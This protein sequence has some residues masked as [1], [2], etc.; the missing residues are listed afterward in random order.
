MRTL[1]LAI[2]EFGFRRI[3]RMLQISEGVIHLDH[4]EICRILHILRK[5][6]SIIV[7]LFLQN[8]SKYKNKLKHANLGRCKFISITHFY[9]ELQEKK[10]CSGACFS[11]VTPLNCSGS[12]SFFLFAA[13]AFKINA[14]MIL[15]MTIW[16]YQLTKQNRPVCEL[17]TSLLFNWF[18]FQ[19]LPSDPK[20]YRTFREA[21]PRCAN[22]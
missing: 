9:R 18:W 13:F 19:N 17:G 14:S 4:S 15:K 10:V 6:N 1:Y 3:W 20:S 7:L 12:K 22:I 8:D 2:I 21:G 16:N 5:P 11:K